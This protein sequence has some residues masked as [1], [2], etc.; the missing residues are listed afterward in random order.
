MNISEI[1]VRLRAQATT[2]NSRVY[3]AADFAVQFD[4]DTAVDLPHA[5][6][7]FVG[8]DV[9][10]NQTAGL[11]SQRIDDMFGVVVAV[12]NNDVR[13]QDASGQ[14]DN[15]R[16]EL[17]TALVGW[18]PDEAVDAPFDYEGSVQMKITRSRVWHQFK[19]STFHLF[20][21]V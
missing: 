4:A 15:I 7:L 1:I 11:A 19:F 8:D 2:F 20:Q 16:D 9:E 12:A 14:L 6:V 5:F 21:Q 18:S 3:G 13:G 10:P 17:L